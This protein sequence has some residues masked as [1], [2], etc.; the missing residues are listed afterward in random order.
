PRQVDA[1]VV[2]HAG[3]VGEINPF[4]EA[5]RDLLLGREP[6]PAQ[7]AILNDDHLAR[8]ERADF[9][10][11]EVEQGDT[12]AGGGEEWSVLGVAERPEPLGIAD[13]RQVAHSIQEY[14][15]VGAVEFLAQ[16][17]ED[18]HEIRTFLSPQLVA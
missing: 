10:E 13:H 18:V 4:E 14:Y 3:D 2:E 8:F 6:F 7:L 9:G 15:V 12:L 5:M 11:T 16:V 1:A 17:V